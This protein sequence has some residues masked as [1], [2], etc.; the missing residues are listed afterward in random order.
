[1]ATTNV[2]N[3]LIN[4][5][6][7]AF[8][9]I[10]DGWGLADG[11]TS[12]GVG[13]SVVSGRDGRRGGAPYVNQLILGNNGGPAS[14]SC[15]GW[16]TYALP[17]CAASVYH[18]SVE[19]IEHKYPILVRSARLLADSGG[20]GR[21]RGAPASEVIFGPTTEPMTVH[22][23]GDGDAHPPKGVRGGSPGQPCSAAKLE[24]DGTRTSLPPIGAVD[25]APGEWVVG[26]ECGGG[27]YGNPYDRDPEHVLGDVREGWVTAK[28]A[29]NTY[30]VVYSGSLEDDSLR[31]DVSATADRRRR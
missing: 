25:L 26:I 13:F 1:M 4:A 27:G 16:I 5:T 29:T 23:F 24:S 15:D 6:Q 30:G 12:M 14:A 2:V 11:G 17:D 3:R 31:V 10:G 22:Y 20:A 21:F 9:A 19:I 28:Q 7:T 8:A 18:D